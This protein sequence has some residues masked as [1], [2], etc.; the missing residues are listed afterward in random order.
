MNHALDGDPDRHARRGNFLRKG[1]ADRLVTPRG[2]KCTRP[3][4]T[5]RWHYRPRGT[6]AF[7]AAGGEGSGEYTCGGDAAFGQITLTTCLTL[8]D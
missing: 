6:N 4:P 3:P 5:L 8:N 7:D 1:H 2:G